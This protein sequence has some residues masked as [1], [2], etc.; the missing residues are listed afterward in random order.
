M[1]LI[2]RPPLLKMAPPGSHVVRRQARIS[3]A[4]LRYYVKAHVRKNRGKK[5]VL[6][7]ENI[8]Y[9]FWH[10]DQEFPG[11]GKVKGYS[12]YP[13]LDSV[14]QFWLD[15]WKD[16]GLKFPKD[17]DPFL[18]KVIIAIESR[19]RP[20]VKTKD[21]KSSATGLMQ[22]TNQTREGLNG[23]SGR[24]RYALR[25]RFIDLEMKDLTEPV[26]NIAVGI[27]WLS[28]KYTNPR[29]G[30]A[31]NLFNMLR[32]YYDWHNGGETYAHKV[33]NLYTASLVERLGNRP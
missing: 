19:F 26:I 23:K 5:V 4:G 30:A 3:K 22:I 9:L 6:L 13:E 29:T 16:E 2:R 33:L 12:E 28:Y 1:S 10:G 21:P 20:G 32:G 11:L 31:K 14:I 25:D 15:F 27:R 24:S 8:L 18:I 17:L 7:P